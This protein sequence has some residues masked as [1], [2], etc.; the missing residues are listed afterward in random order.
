MRRTL[1]YMMIS[2]VTIVIIVSVYTAF[3]SFKQF[4]EYNVFKTD[5]DNAGGV[6][7]HGVCIDKSAVIYT[8]K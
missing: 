3:H 6:A 2:A 1:D 4:H 7:A 5:C 8:F